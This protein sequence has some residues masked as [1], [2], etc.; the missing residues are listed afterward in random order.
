V[1]QFHQQ[2]REHPR[3][4]GQKVNPS[5]LQDVAE[6]RKAARPQETLSAKK[7]QFF[8]ESVLLHVPEQ[9]QQ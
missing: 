4:R 8:V 9:Y 6:Q 2:H 1:K 3:L 5:Y 7:N